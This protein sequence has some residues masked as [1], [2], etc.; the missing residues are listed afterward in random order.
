MDKLQ[1]MNTFVSVVEA[2][3]FV[4]AM[5][6]AGLSKPAVSRQVAELEQ[7]LG[8]RLL[9]RTTRRLSLTDEGRI[10]Y[11]RCKEV[12]AAVQEAEDETSSRAGQAHGRLR[13]GAPHDF[14]VLH[15]AP[16]WA[17]FMAHNPQ[18]ELDIVLSDRT[19]DLIEE[20]YDLV[21]RIGNLPNSGLVARPLANTRMVLCAAPAYLA[22]HGMPT[23]PDNL[24]THAIIA[25]SYWSNG[26]EWRFQH[27]DGQRASLRVRARA[28]A[29]SGSTCLALA[30]ASQGI[31]L[32][33]D[34][35]VYDAL[36]QGTLVE[37]MPAWQAGTIA[38]HAL[39]PTRTLL[40]L[41]VQLLRDF[42]VEALRQPPWRLPAAT[43]QG[44]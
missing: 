6:T 22:A 41:K 24:A 18:V 25:Y 39:Y 1:A 19:V 31:I 16:L 28:H 33:P 37:I 13:V 10:Y 5:E 30:L 23:H 17:S 32:Q 29:N 8:V 20:G 44:A 14:G 34:F 11:L 36:A 42:L 40:P 38:M 7:H 12:L 35:L 3:S 21:V 15:L 4:G 27:A 43:D 26:D 2:G 9:H